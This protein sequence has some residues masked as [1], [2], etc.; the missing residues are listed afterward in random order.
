MCNNLRRAGIGAR[1]RS[2]PR[3]GRRL[4][5]VLADYRRD[6]SGAMSILALFS[7]LILIVIGGI[8]IDLMYAEYKRNNIQNALDRAVLAAADLEQVL[9]PTAVVEDYFDKMDMPDALTSVTV[10]QGLN[11]KDVTGEAEI[12]TPANFTRYLGVDSLTS[13]GLSRAEERIANVEISMVLDISGSMA[14][15]DKM[16]NLQAAADTFIDTVLTDQNEDLVSIS[17][18]PYSEH[19]NAGPDITQHFDVDWRHGYSH[20]LEVDEWQFDSTELA[21]DITYEQAQHYQW[22]YSGSNARDDTVCPRYS[23]ERITPL[24]QNA[25]ALKNQ[26]AQFQPRAGTSIFMGVKWATALLSPGHRPLVTAMVGDG[27]VENVFSGRPADW[28]DVNTLKTI[29]LM[30]DGQHDRSYR[31]SDWA[32]NSESEISHWARYN[33][34]YYLQRNVSSRYWSSVYYQKYSAD[35]GDGLMDRICDAAKDQ[36]IVIWSIGFE[37]TDHGADVMRSCASSP[38]H[39]YRVEGIEI[40][41]A[42]YSIARAINQLRLVQ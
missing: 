12:T 20:C 17:L 40:E 38:A 26:I 37:V 2:A 32:Y 24:S 18:V 7:A 34:W 5:Q 41:D 15:N 30:T 11:Y 29:V 39:F 13:A 19:V 42:F 16:A 31:I 22:N 35:I 25:T 33:L 27:D 23:Y 21:T 6:E 4:R 36:G 3:P 28:D 9:E 8:G 1:S 14:N 10:D